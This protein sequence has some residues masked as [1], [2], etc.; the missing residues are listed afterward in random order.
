MLRED[1]FG[2]AL[3][4]FTNKRRNRVKLLYW[5]GTGVWVLAAPEQFEKIGEERS[6]EVDVVPTK[7]FKREFVRPKYRAKAQLDRAPVVAPARVRPVE[8][9]Y[10]SAGLLAWVL[11]SKYVDHAPRY[12]L[13]KMSSRWGARLPRQSMVEWVRIASDWLE[14]I[15]QGMRRRLLESRLRASR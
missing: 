4:V 14:P 5:D 8:G 13:E 6:F 15:Y 11:I 9:G 3:F 2:G 7:L 10:A 1:P 12:R